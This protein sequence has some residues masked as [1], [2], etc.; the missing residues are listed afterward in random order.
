MFFFLQ[1]FL[2][3]SLAFQNDF[4]FNLHQRPLK[5]ISD[6]N[7]NY[8]AKCFWCWNGNKIKDFPFFSFLQLCST[9]IESLDPVAL[10]FVVRP[11]LEHSYY[12]KPKHFKYRCQH[13][14]EIPECDWK[15]NKYVM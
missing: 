13:G 6:F 10:K 4:L 12:Q 1:T 14:R 3:V 2:L 15:L 7:L 9:S 11:Y 8:F 5:S